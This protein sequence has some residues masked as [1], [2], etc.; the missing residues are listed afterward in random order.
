MLASLV[1]AVAMIQGSALP[2]TEPLEMTADMR[3]FV[4]KKVDRGLP[5]LERLKALDMAIFQD[6]ELQFNYSV[7]TR[8][9]SE[10]FYARNGN[11]LSFTLL[12]I[13]MARYLG[14]DVRFREAEIAPAFSLSGSYP[15]L[16]LHVNAAII[17]G[18]SAYI[19]DVFPGVNRTEIGGRVVPDERGFAHFYNNR[20]V[21]ELAKE[22]MAGAELYFRRALEIDPTTAFIWINLGVVKVHDAEYLE[23]EKFYRKALEMDPG[24]PVAISNLAVVCEK[25]GRLK[26]AQRYQ[27]KV[28]SI[29]GRNPYY[30]YI[31]GIRSYETGDYAQSIAHYRKA[32]KLKSTDHNF[33]FALARACL[34]LSRPEEA[35]DNL[36]LAI[37]YAVDPTRRQ[38]YSQKLEYLMS[39]IAPPEGATH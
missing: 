24:D 9:A 20:G 16:I 29:Q 23:A 36:R 34:Q 38:R 22:N 13:A 37:K 10:T 12:F 5:Q 3:A 26:E 8:T 19:V 32:I 17:I 7:E 2:S 33:Y 4:E 11:C 30:H 1:L 18:G 21:A 27:A 28:K 39:S 31:L 15:T 35:R 14:L 6:R 25:T